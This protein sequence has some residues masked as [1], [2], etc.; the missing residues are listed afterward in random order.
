VSLADSDVMFRGV[1]KD[2]AGGRIETRTTKRNELFRSWDVDELRE[3]TWEEVVGE[4]E[5]EEDDWER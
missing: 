4:E 1:V 2:E 3:T 5:K